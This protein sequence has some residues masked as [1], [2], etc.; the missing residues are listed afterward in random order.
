MIRGRK[1]VVQDFLVGPR[2]ADDEAALVCQRPQRRIVAIGSQG[3]EDR[4]G[5]RFG[6]LVRC[7]RPIRVG[8]EE[9]GV[10]HAVC[11][12][13]VD[14]M[15]SRRRDGLAQ[16]LPDIAAAARTSPSARDGLLVDLDGHLAVSAVATDPDLPSGLTGEV[17][18][19]G[20]LRLVAAGG[21]GGR[22]AQRLRP[23]VLAAVG[24]E[25]PRRHQPLGGGPEHG[26]R[27]SVTGEGSAAAATSGAASTSQPQ[28][29]MQAS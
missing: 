13:Y 26:R 6:Q 1:P 4:L 7:R 23:A 16:M 22:S 27:P 21:P 17:G 20:E 14:V 28:E 29:T 3:A 18:D 12:T 9:H 8:G 19:P 24:I 15:R 10:E 5:D 2:Q 11:D 25:P